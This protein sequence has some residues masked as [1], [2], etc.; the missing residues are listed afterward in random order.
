[1][2]LPE[3][4]KRKPDLS[5]EA[6][7]LLLARLASKPEAAAREYERLRIGLANYFRIKGCFCD[8]DLADLTLDRVAQLLA[9]KKVGRVVPF[10][11]GV[12]RLICH[13]QYR[14]EQR[15]RSANEDFIRAVNADVEADRYEAMKDCLAKLTEQDQQLLRSY[16]A[17][18]L[19][20]DRTA[21]REGL[22]ERAGIS[23][24]RLRLRVHRLRRKLEDCLNQNRME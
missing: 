20:K 6:F 3:A 4:H 14:S 9:S 5:T 21:H 13:E 16:F 17:D 2:E 23:L 11:F 7:Q 18:L 1:M 19:P 22:A 12:A 8:F 24:E 15:Q 10:C